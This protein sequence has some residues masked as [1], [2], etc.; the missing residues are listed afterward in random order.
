MSVDLFVIFKN[1]LFLNAPQK[2]LHETNL[3]MHQVHV[4]AVMQVSFT[5][6]SLCI[7]DHYHIIKNRLIYILVIFPS[8]TS[9]TK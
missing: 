8:R 1:K 5:L 3:K 6:S 4:F 7:R 9:F 2:S